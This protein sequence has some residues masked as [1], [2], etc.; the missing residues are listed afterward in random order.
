LPLDRPTLAH[1]RQGESEKGKNVYLNDILL[2]LNTFW[3]STASI[4]AIG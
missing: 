3:G 2:L 1:K 4:G